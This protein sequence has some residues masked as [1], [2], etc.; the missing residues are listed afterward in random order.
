MNLIIRCKR[1]IKRPLKAS[2]NDLDNLKNQ[3][4][5]ATTGVPGAEKEDSVCEHVNLLR[6]CFQDVVAADSDDVIG[7]VRVVIGRNKTTSATPSTSLS[8]PP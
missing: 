2:Q 8:T 3:I 1:F 4:S 5:S 7:D 6:R